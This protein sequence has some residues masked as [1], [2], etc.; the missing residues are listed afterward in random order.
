[1][2]DPFPDENTVIEDGKQLFGDEIIGIDQLVYPQSK[3][4]KDKSPKTI[5][6]PQRNVMIK[7]IR[8]SL[9]CE[10]ESDLWFN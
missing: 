4:L 6:I 1:M 5:F 9:G 2:A 8:A 7:M 3:Y 10:S